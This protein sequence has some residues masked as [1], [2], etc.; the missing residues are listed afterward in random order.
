MLVHVFRLAGERWNWTLA[1]L[2]STSLALPLS[3]I[4]PL[5]GEPGS[6]T[7]PVGLTL[8]TK[9]AAW[10]AIQMPLLTVDAALFVAAMAGMSL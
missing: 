9:K 10:W 5:S 8:S 2:E 1:T 6:V 3:V 4:V 7:L